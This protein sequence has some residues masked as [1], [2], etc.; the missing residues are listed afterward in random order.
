VGLQGCTTTILISVAV[1]LDDGNQSVSK[2]SYTT[3]EHISKGGTLHPTTT[4]L[5]QPCYCCSI[6]NNQKTE[7]NLDFHQQ[8]NRTQSLKMEL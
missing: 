7:N 6:H 4:V 3:L 1:P 5:A 2:S 8:Y